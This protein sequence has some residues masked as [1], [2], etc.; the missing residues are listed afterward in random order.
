VL[1]VVSRPKR[2]LRALLSM[3]LV[4]GVVAIGGDAAGADTAGLDPAFGDRGTVTIDTSSPVPVSLVAT[5]PLFTAAAVGDRFGFTG[6]GRSGI[7]FGGPARAHGIADGGLVV[8]EALGDFGLARFGQGGVADFG[9]GSLGH[10]TIDFGGPSQAWAAVHTD[11]NYGWF[12]AGSAKAGS[13][14]RVAL[15]KVSEYGALDPTFGNGGTVTADVGSGDDEVRAMI[16]TARVGLVVAGRSGGAAMVARFDVNGVLDKTF[17]VNG[18]ARLDLSAGDDI[19]N[20]V[21]LDSNYG[22]MVTGRAGSRAFVSR[23]T[24][25]GQLDPKF[26]TAGTVFID[27]GGKTSEARGIR[28][29]GRSAIV[30]GVTGDAAN[31]DGAIAR[32]T[33]PGTLDPAFGVGGIVVADFGSPTD[34]LNDLNADQ[35]TNTITAVG[36]TGADGV[37]WHLNVVGQPDT[38]FSPT[39]I[40]YNGWRSVEDANGIAA[41]G[42]DGRIVVASTSDGTLT[43]SRLEP[44]GS[45]DR[46]FGIDGTEISGFTA[47]APVAVAVAPDGGIVVRGVRGGYLSSFLARFLPDGRLDTTFA[48]GGAVEFRQAGVASGSHSLLIQPD[49]R[50]VTAGGPGLMAR[51]LPDGGPDL[52][53][54]DHGVLQPPGSTGT[55]VAVSLQSDGTYLVAASDP[56]WSRTDVFKVGANGHEAT[57]EFQGGPG[58]VAT[59]LVPA[60]DGGAWVTGTIQ[61]VNIKG[62]AVTRLRS[63]L[64]PDSAFGDGGTVEWSGLDPYLYAPALAGLPDGRVAVSFDELDHN[65]TASGIVTVLDARGDVESS[66]GDSGRIELPA[67]FGSI[68][69]LVIAGPGRLL[70]VTATEEGRGSDVL[71]AAIPTAPGT[72]SRSGPAGPGT[73][74]SGVSS[75]TGYWMTTAAGQVFAFGNA[76]VFGDAA[77]KL[78]RA[79]AVD[80]EPVP[81]GDGYWILD[82]S[83]AVYAFGAAAFHGRVSTGALTAGEE[84]TSLSA[85]PDGG[86]Y[87]IFTNRGRVLA[88]G[89]APFL[90]DMS[91]VKLNGPVLGSVA[92]PTGAGYFMVASDGGIFAFGDA[93]FAGSMGGKR[94]N[95]PVQSLVPDGDGHGYWLVASDGGIF[96]FDAPFRGSMGAT[97]L[98]KPISGMVRYGDGYLMVGADGGI[99]DFSTSPFA[100]SLGDKPPAS[101]VVAVAALTEP[102]ASGVSGAA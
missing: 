16:P 100:G 1:S 58:M 64:H 34:E 12:V 96:A 70:A 101:P 24:S 45:P 8:G 29:I 59:D 14:S 32:V 3:L 9:F 39:G 48:G 102:S 93:A 18:V 21:A 75:T 53:F 72:G 94:L 11:D 30:V 88:F 23:L 95:A 25:D 98:N 61:N 86:G 55:G 27:F 41:V 80:L 38:T 57:I 5:N 71:V 99:F 36:G 13:S 81:G 19:A 50:I 46:S 60:L 66:F 84:A 85:T 28:T 83:G 31:T 92:T 63:D 69:P 22:I 74:T 56:Q 40:T 4:A 54:G 79:R 6:T 35:G 89:D 44:D 20:G 90:G 42:P 15:A 47:S 2:R 26:G 77:G 97:K 67:T 78:G 33:G 43:L 62:V 65:T 51:F 87:W 49:G 10:E 52:T 76:R 7:S 82:N 68:N 17:G 73:G 37:V 91:A